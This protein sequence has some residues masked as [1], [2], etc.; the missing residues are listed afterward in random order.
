[1]KTAIAVFCAVACLACESGVPLQ[2][3]DYSAL[4]R[5]LVADGQVLPPSAAMASG[6]SPY[7]PVVYRMLGDGAP[8]TSC[9]ASMPRRVS[10]GSFSADRASTM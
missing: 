1:M 3:V 9:A 5:R 4:S 10:A 2:D 6:M 8:A 7:V